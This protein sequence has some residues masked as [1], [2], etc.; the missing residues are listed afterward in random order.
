MLGAIGKSTD[1][2]EVEGVVHHL[3]RRLYAYWRMRLRHGL[4]LGANQ[5]DPRYRSLDGKAGPF[6]CMTQSERIC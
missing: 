2:S 1:R 3:A 4:G 6:R 5:A